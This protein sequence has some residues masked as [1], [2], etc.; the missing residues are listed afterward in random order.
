MTL[1]EMQKKRREYGYSYKMLS[2]LSGVPESTIQ[3][4]FRGQTESPRYETIQRLQSVLQDQSPAY[5]AAPVNSDLSTENELSSAE[6]SYPAQGSYTVEDYE[7]IE[8]RRVELIN[9]VIYDM[10]SPAT[11]HQMISMEIIFQIQSFIRSRHG[12]CL[13]FTAPID[14]QLNR[15]NKTILQPDIIILC[16][17]D[18]L[19]EKRVF[20]A[21]DF[22]LEIISPSTGKK[23]Y[24]IKL[25][26]YISA[27]VREYWIVDPYQK[28]IV[29][30][31]FES[32]S[33]PEI[34]P[35]NAPV[36]VNIFNGELVI[37]ISELEEWLPK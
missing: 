5:S 33:G 15:D 20:G 35:I 2:E 31:N 3:K 25:N 13:P 32:E 14:V 6:V 7:A 11:V 24:F 8:D 12:D 1:D 18:L 21:P 19:T 10:A 34:Y 17:R 26:Q 29:V 28:K 30:Y 27:G 22:V 36:P 23:D 9:G 37:D 16:K 4:I